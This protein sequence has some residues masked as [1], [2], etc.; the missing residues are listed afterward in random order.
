VH[1]EALPA[2]LHGL[3]RAIEHD[4]ECGELAVDVVLGLVADRR[5]L[6]LSVLEP[7]SVDPSQSAETLGRFVELRSQLGETLEQEEAK[8]LLRELKAVGG[9]LKALRLALTGAE[10]GPE[11]WAVL[12]ALPRD[13]ALRRA[14]P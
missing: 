11:L 2:L 14:L 3:H 10:R 8:T 5:G 12:R 1:L 13:E 4:L 6:A 9:S 7:T